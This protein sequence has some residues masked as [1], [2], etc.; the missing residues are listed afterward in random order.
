MRFRINKKKLVGAI[1][2][3]LVLL[4]IASSAWFFSL[5]KNNYAK[6]AIKPFET[7]LEKNGAKKL[8][9]NGDSG[10]GSDNRKPWIHLL[11]E[12][13]GNKER[14]ARLVVQSAKLSGLSL[15]S[16]NPPIDVQDNAFYIDRSA[17]SNNE[18]LKQGNT[19]LI[20]EIFGS[21]A[22]SGD[23]TSCTV[24]EQKTPSDDQTTID[25]TLTLPEHRDGF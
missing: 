8:C 17:Y 1:I 18:F 24:V 6:E 4:A 3:F 9:E 2:I 10:R 13:P 7:A 20:V 21:R 19:E 5:A 23:H 16:Y 25:V 14:A 11:Y 12:I 15:S 22:F